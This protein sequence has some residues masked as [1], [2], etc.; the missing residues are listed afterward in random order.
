MLFDTSQTIDVDMCDAAVDGVVPISSRH[1]RQANPSHSAAPLSDFSTIRGQVLCGRRLQQVRALQDSILRFGLLAPLT[2]V[3]SAGRLVVVDGRLRLAALRR[4]SFQG[5][6]PEAL[7][8]VPF[9]VASTTEAR[10]PASRAMQN[11][12][13]YA[14]VLGRFQQGDGLDAIAERFQIPR[15]CVRDVLSLA[16]L[17]EAVRRS[18]FECLISVAQARAFAQIGSRAQQRRVLMRLGPFATPR[19]IV[20]A[21]TLVS[22]DTPPRAAIPA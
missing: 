10:T 22:A 21:A 19:A 4:L 5:R 20:E 8:R 1:V 3:R 14:A 2:A 12:A 9:R 16:R 15:E 18:L 13:L 7:R 11:A 17:D 6:L